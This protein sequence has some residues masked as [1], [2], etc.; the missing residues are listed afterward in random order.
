MYSGVGDKSGRIFCN[1]NNSWVLGGA[2][3]ECAVPRCLV[4]LLF[5]YIWISKQTN[6]AALTRTP[7]PPTPQPKRRLSELVRRHSRRFRLFRNRGETGASVLKG[8]GRRRS[9][10]S[11]A[12]TINELSDSFSCSVHLKSTSQGPPISNAGKRRVRFECPENLEQIQHLPARNKKG[13]SESRQQHYNSRDYTQIQTAMHAAA[14]AAREQGL[15]P[16]LDLGVGDQQTASNQRLINNWAVLGERGLE[17][18]T[19]S[20]HGFRRHTQSIRHI[21]TVMQMQEQMALKR[22]DEKEE[23]RRA[24]L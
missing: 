5:H 21:R 20:R 15:A 11:A 6:M 13:V 22:S 17:C 18:I 1:Q 12:A 16:L 3:I 7:S 8:T 2:T 23:M 19:N 9:D 14:M 24:S 4:L 10:S